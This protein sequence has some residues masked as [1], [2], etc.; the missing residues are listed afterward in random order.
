MKKMT[1]PISILLSFISVS[2]FAASE[3]ILFTLNGKPVKSVNVD[4]LSKLNFSIKT[5]NSF[6][7][8]YKNQLG[9][10][11]NALVFIVKPFKK[12]SPVPDLSTY[13]YFSELENTYS[14]KS[15]LDKKTSSKD[16]FS[17]AKRTRLHDND[18]TENLAVGVRLSRKEYTG[19]TIWQN[20]GWVQETRWVNVGPVL[21]KTVLSLEK[22]TFEKSI[23]WDSIMKEAVEN[24]NSKPASVNEYNNPIAFVK[25]IFDGS[26][27]DNY[28]GSKILSVKRDGEPV[29]SWNY[30]E[31]NNKSYVNIKVPVELNIHAVK[32]TSLGGYEGSFKCRSGLEFNK[33]SDKSSFD[34]GNIYIGSKFRE[35]CVTPDGKKASEINTNDLSKTDPNQ[36][37]NDIMKNF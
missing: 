14:D 19:K 29:Y 5:S 35:S 11:D 24:T 18:N 7:Q 30:N 22:P 31:D 10:L 27:S 17:I 37:I 3:E 23:N 34:K 13:S 8:I 12:G 16:M 9:N 20:G 15:W 1:V 6:R 26:S 21:G 32:K 2:S 33:Y 25:D 36:L 28:E 4:N